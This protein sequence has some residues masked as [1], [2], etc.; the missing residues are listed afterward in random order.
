MSNELERCGNIVSGLLSFSRE[1]PLEYKDIDL[2]E[3]L[4][5]V[6]T[7]TRHKMELQNIEF[8]CNTC[9]GILMVTGDS[10][11]LQQTLLNLVFNAIE[12]MPKGGRLEIVSRSDER[13]KEVIIEIKDSGNGISAEHLD[14]IFDPFFTTKKE[15]EGTGLGLSIVYGVVNNH[16]GKIAVQSTK[17]E[18]TAFTLRFPRLKLEKH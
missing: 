9:P 16:R 2:N 14:H 13:E 11:R 10:N 6:I 18:G 12:A 1:I 5:A 3:V 8:V 17:G 4:Q 7:L 15:G